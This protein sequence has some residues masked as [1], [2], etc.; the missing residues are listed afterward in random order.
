MCSPELV[1]LPNP[2][3][4]TLFTFLRGILANGVVLVDSDRRLSAAWKEVLLSNTARGQHIRIY[5]EEILKSRPRC[6]VVS[7]PKHSR[8]IH[9]IDLGSLMSFRDSCCADALVLS[10]FAGDD[11]RLV[12]M[13]NYAFK[14]LRDS[15]SELPKRH[16]SIG[17]YVSYRA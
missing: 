14:R 13:R 7:D 12:S 1:S 11:M 6:L 9:V 5:V 17:R 3:T 15:A 4:R 10:D 8:C 16:I 2:T